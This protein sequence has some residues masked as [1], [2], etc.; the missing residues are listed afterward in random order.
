MLKKNKTTK[1][2]FLDRDGIIN[3]VIMRNG[4]VSCP[5]KFNEFEIF[6]D[7]KP[8]LKE[9][10]KMGF[11]N[12][13]FTNQPDVARGFLKMPELEKMHN[14]IIKELLADEIKFC[15]HD[16]SDNCS[17]RKPKPG[18]ILQVAQKWG[19]DLEQSYVIGDSW[20]DIGAGKSAGCKTFLLNREYNK[21][22][23]CNHDFA[24]NNIEEAVEIIKKL[25]NSN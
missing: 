12:I 15:P 17:C 16:D 8:A 2:I 13:I 23:N 20:K 5:W 24:V 21:D 9:F 1:A 18:L 10:K 22:T 25:N 6:P 14:F 3:K 19:I 11:L 7:A 4:E